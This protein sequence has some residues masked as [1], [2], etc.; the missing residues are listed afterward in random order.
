MTQ[1][2]VS[3]HDDHDEHHHH[4]EHDSDVE[5]VAPPWTDGKRYAWLL[6]LV[7]PTIPFICWGFAS[8]TGLGIFWW[9]GP[10]FIFAVMPLLDQLGGT[11]NGN[12]PDS[13]IKWLEA[14][15]YYRWC[16]YLFIPLQLASTVFSAW[17][18]SRGTLSVVESVGLAMSLG[19]SNGIAIANAHELGHKRES[20]EKW[21]AKIA[22]AP[23]FYGHFFI[24]HNRGHHVRVSTPEDPASSRLGENFYE[25]LPRTVGGSV[26][27]AWRIE[28]RRYARKQ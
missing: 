23:T 26:K 14:D 19:V 20:I 3:D 12:P 10:L 2:T 11:D 5:P 25:F 24:E 27:S 7:V 28:K 8:A 1:A 6:G 4:H 21:L 9:C 13:A 15:T 18:W 17:M 22:L 16:T